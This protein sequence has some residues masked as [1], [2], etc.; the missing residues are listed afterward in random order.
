MNLDLITGMIGLLDRHGYTRGDK[1]HTGRAILL[2]GDMARI[3]E[4]SQDHPFGPSTGEIPPRPEP[5]PPE[6]ATRDAVTVPPGEVKTL[7]SALIIA[8][9]HKRDRAGICADCAD[10]SCP[11]CEWRLRDAQAYDRA[12]VQLLQSADAWAAASH[13]NP[14]PSPRRSRRLA[15]DPAA[16]RPGTRPPSSRLT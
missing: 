3:Y 16:R 14:P 5:V 2:L 6:P 8:A 7:I 10:Q 9:D 15:S 1:E 11:A 12:H 4:G 13:P